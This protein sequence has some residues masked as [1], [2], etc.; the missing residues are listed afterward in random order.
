MSIVHTASY[1]PDF[2]MAVH[3][4]GRRRMLSSL[5]RLRPTSSCDW[6][7]DGIE[8]GWNQCPTSKKATYQR[9]MRKGETHTPCLCVCLC[10]SMCVLTRIVMD[11]TSALVCL[12]LMSAWKESRYYNGIWQMKEWLQAYIFTNG[13]VKVHLHVLILEEGIHTRAHKYFT[14]MHQR[15]HYSRGLQTKAWGLH[16][17]QW[18]I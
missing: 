15:T 9:D 13:L 17:T 2:A 12:Y 16:V 8:A 3:W 11:F 5:E 4:S 10:V 7:P 14:P 1:H 18:P 6:Q